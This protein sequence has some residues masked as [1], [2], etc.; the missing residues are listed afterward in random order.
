MEKDIQLKSFDFFKREPEKIKVKNLPKSKGKNKLTTTDQILI[1]CFVGIMSLMLGAMVY[2]KYQ[3]KTVREKVVHAFTS[4]NIEQDL[5][6]LNTP[7]TLSKSRDK[8]NYSFKISTSRLYGLISPRIQFYEIEKNLTSQ[9]LTLRDQRLEGI[10]SKVDSYKEI[11]KGVKI[12]EIKTL[13]NIKTG[14][15]DISFKIED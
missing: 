8:T 10:D 14:A 3:V 5:N 11:L 1:S 12:A 15:I 4:G 13:L 2:E 9:T 7:I 6:Q